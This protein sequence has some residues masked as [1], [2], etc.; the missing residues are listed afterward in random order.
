MMD[1]KRWHTLSLAAQMGNIASEL[2]RAYHFEKKNDDACREN[3]FMRAFELIDL[4]IS[5]QRY[6]KKLKELTRLR[7]VICNWYSRSN[8]YDV[9]PESIQKYCID[10]SLH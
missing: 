9:S 6:L 4:T 3:S 10:F 8:T 7:E 5:D 2:S 1:Q